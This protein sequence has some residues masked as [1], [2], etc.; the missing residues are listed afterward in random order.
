VAKSEK[1]MTSRR[2]AAFAKTGCA[3]S[4]LVA[5]ALVLTVPG[6]AAQTAEPTAATPAP[7]STPTPTISKH[8]A[9]AKRHLTR[10]AAR[11]RAAKGLPPA[12]APQAGKDS[13]A[14]EA[15]IRAQLGIPAS[16]PLSQNDIGLIL[17]RQQTAARFDKVYGVKGWDVPYPTTDDSLLQD[18]G[19]FRSNLAN[20]GLGFFANTTLLGAYNVLDVN[21]HGLGPTL[22]NGTYSNQQY[23]GQVPSN[24]M[25]TNAY[26]TYDLSRYG[27]PDGQF[28]VEGTWSWSNWDPYIPRQ[29]GMTSF[30]YYQTLF[31]KALEIKIGYIPNSIEW[32]G[33]SVGGNIANPLGAAAT[34]PYEMGISATPGTQ[35]TAR[36]TYHYNEAIYNEA[37][38]MRSMP[39][40]GT[41]RNPLLDNAVVNPTGWDFSV[42]NGNL[43]VMDEVGLKIPAVPGYHS[44][45]IRAGYMYNDSVFPDYRYM[46]QGGTKRGVSAGY[47]IGDYQVLQFEPNS[48]F[49]AFRGLY[50]G[51][52]AMLAPEANIP[53]NQYYELRAYVMGPFE[54]RPQDQISLVYDYNGISK[55]IGQTINAYAPYTGLYAA[56][57][58]N[59]GMV[60]YTAHV[61]PGV[62]ATLGLGY[63]DNPSLQYTKGE[64]SALNILGALFLNY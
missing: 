15:A 40:N 49:T 54:S 22:P 13:A 31:N 3:V 1:K 30:S 10:N 6:A 45:W 27:I 11:A 53:F 32:V 2:F 26:L 38:V 20:Y 14:T 55:Y 8:T 46:L 51:G 41:T 28:L 17:Q 61:Q 23:W 33:M 56:R 63:T 62:Y 57:S 12:P 21:R 4:A 64:G 7:A 42:P 37:G 52:T 48:L 18:N 16:I 39:I 47:L 19:G 24:G 29:L 58:A 9:E 43:L 59:T 50:V 34:V 36:V 25:V 35:P 44:T 5:G 60:S